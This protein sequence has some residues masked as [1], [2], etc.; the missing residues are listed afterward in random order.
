MSIKF[1]MHR[2]HL[3]P[4]KNDLHKIF[5]VYF[6]NLMLADFSFFIFCL[7]STTLLGPVDWGVGESTLHTRSWLKCKSVI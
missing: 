5:G 4:V 6:Q 3:L 1:E 2:I 7:P